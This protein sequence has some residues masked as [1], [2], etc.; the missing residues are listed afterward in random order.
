[1]LDTMEAK[2]Q[3]PCMADSKENYQWDLGSKRVKAGFS[4]DFCWQKTNEKPAVVCVAV[5]F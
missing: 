1:M 4:F 5:F 3:F 2:F